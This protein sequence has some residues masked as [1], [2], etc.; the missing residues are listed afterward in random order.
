MNNRQ[1]DEQET[2]NAL[3]VMH[4]IEHL[5]RQPDL[6]INLDLICHINYLIL[7]NTDRD[8]WAGRVRSE[9]D[10]QHPADWTRRRAIVALDEQGLAVADDNTGKLL[11]R[12]LSDREVGPL[13][14]ELLEWINSS[15]A[16]ALHSV[17]R[18][19]LFH[20]RFTAIHPFR[21][22]NGRT[23]RALT[24]LLL[25]R[26]GF[27][28]EILRLQQVLDMQRETYVNTLRA[29]DHGDMQGWIQFFAQAV[30]TAL[31]S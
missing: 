15:M 10:W 12:F 17:V 25:W 19:A 2:R 8:Y 20:Q 3:E 22:G 7:R 26:A 30:R 21:D 14:D 4:W 5:A 1:R 9:V 24:T 13:L 28:L 16:F 6:A 29:A 27:S 11:A 23:A 18:S 31:Q